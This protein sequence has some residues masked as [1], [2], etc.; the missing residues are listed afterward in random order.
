MIETAF[1][2]LEDWAH[3]QIFDP[4]EIDKERGVVIE[5]WRL[6]QGASARIRDKQFPILF[7]GSQY[8]ERLPIG[9]LES[10]QNFEYESLKRFYRAWYIPDLMGFIAVGDFDE[11][12]IRSLLE[13]H[14]KDIPRPADARLR[15]IYEIP[16]HDE[17]LIAIA[18]DRELQGTNVSVYYKQPLRDQS[19]VG[20]YRQS[21]VEGLYNGILNRRLSEL[22]QKAEP[23]F[24]FGISNRSLF[25]RSKE[26]YLLSAVVKEDGISLGLETLLVEAERVNRFGFTI[27]ELE[28]Q[29][30]AILRSI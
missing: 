23:P 18:R 22:T 7:K 25:I 13:K 24:L 28:L 14:F 26:V 20:A 4:E 17:T 21:I 8:A 5:E 27:S 3:G 29:M 12:V 9:T 16:D 6:G 2:I 30:T 19:T 15:E 10:L 11:E 1:Q